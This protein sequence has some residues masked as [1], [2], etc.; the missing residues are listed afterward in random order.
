M[1]GAPGQV[2]GLHGITRHGK[3]W[4]AQITLNR[5]LYNS[6]TFKTSEEAA[7]AHDE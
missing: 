2:A 5:K 7:Q 1:P 4:W 6:T 3:G